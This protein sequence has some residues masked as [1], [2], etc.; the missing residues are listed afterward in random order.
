MS[1]F[2][3]SVLFIL[4]V[5][6]GG[7]IVVLCCFVFIS[8]LGDGSFCAEEIEIEPTTNNPLRN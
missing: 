5:I 2:V 6:M 8:S 7:I 4:A 3:L 1:N